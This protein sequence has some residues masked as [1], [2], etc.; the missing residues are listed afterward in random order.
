MILALYEAGV[1]DIVSINDCWLIASDALPA[2]DE[3]KWRRAGS[4][5]PS[6]PRPD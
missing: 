6:R 5:A 1:G 2:L 4:R 3:V